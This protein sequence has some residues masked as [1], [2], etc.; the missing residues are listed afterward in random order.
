[1]NWKGF[2]RKQSGPNVDTTPVFPRWGEWSHEN[3]QSRYQVSRQKF[4]LRTFRIRV[5]SATAVPTGSV[6]RC[7]CKRGTIEYRTAGGAFTALWCFNLLGCLFVCL[8]SVFR[9]WRIAT[10]S[11]TCSTDTSPIDTDMTRLAPNRTKSPCV[12]GCWGNRHY[13]RNKC[14]GIV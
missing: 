12:V 4:E 11:F 2:G 8:G 14:N 3:P 7:P 13:V 6:F 5:E 9:K 1:M 10:R